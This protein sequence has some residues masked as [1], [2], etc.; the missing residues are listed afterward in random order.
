MKR[1]A[2]LALSGLAA[3]TLGACASAPSEDAPDVENEPA[4]VEP[5]K[6]TDLSRV[7]LTPLAAQRVGIATAPIRSGPRGEVIPS[8][9][10]LYDAEGRA[11]VYTSPKPRVFVRAPLVVRSVD[12]ERAILVKGPPVGTRVVTVGATELYGVEFGVEED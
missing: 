9:A 12:G 7:T 8:A 10:I 11:Y 4:R 1:L 3:L 5:I 6:G 2:I